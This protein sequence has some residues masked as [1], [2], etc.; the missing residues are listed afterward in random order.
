MNYLEKHRQ[1][2]YPFEEYFMFIEKAGL[3]VSECFNAFTFD[4]GNAE[5]ERVQFVVRN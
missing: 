2:I 4:N 1:K 5:C 3:Y